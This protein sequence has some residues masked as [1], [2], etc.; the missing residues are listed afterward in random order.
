MDFAMMV[1]DEK[2]AKQLTS[3]MKVP[4]KKVVVI[5]RKNSSAVNA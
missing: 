1:A 3:K 5:K 2:E 4:I